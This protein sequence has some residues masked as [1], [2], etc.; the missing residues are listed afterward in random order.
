MTT[1][2]SQISDTV[3]AA[4]EELIS[5]LQKMVRA[6]SLPDHEH[7][8]QNLIAQKLKA[9]GFEVEISRHIL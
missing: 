2:S 8:A 9:M 7:E 5:F 6:S 3:D 4:R 1:F